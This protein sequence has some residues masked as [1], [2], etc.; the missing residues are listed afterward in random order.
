MTFNINAVEGANYSDGLPRCEIEINGYLENCPLVT[1]LWGLV[2][3]REQW[4]NALLQLYKREVSKCMLVTDI[5]EIHINTALTFWAL[6]AVGE[7]IY[8]RE[9]FI[10][11]PGIEKVVDPFL[12]EEYIYAREDDE[13]EDIFDSCGTKLSV[14]EWTIK[15]EDIAHLVQ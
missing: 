13:D 1:N 15:F 5:N 11:N 10:K 7:L 14:S 2:G 4:R 9:V 8:I 12:I 6:Y 3:Y